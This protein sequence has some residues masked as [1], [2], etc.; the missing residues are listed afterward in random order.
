MKHVLVNAKVKTGLQELNREDMLGL[1]RDHVAKAYMGQ[2]GADATIEKTRNRIHWMAAQVVGDRVLDVGTSEGVLPILLAREGFD[3][4][5]IDI[6]AEAIAFANSLR[7]REPEAIRERVEFRNG[8]LFQ[9]SDDIS[10]DTVVLGEVLEHVANVPKFL[11]NALR[12]LK[13]DGRLV[14][15][16][17]FGVFP[18][19]DHKQTFYLSNIREIL[20]PWGYIEHLSVVDGYI[21]ACLRR[22]GETKPS[23]QVDAGNLLTMTEEAVHAALTA[24]LR[25]VD[26]ER[27]DATHRKKQETERAQAAEHREKQ[28]AERA[29]AAEHREKQQAERAQAAEHREK[30]QAERAQAAEH[31]EKQQAE[32]AQAAEHRE[33]QQAERAQAAEHREK[34]E[35]E[36]KQA[37]EQK[38]SALTEQEERSRALLC[39]V[40]AKLSGVAERVGGLRPALQQFGA[41]LDAQHPAISMSDPRVAPVVDLAKSRAPE[42]AVGVE[43]GGS[44]RLALNFDPATAPQEKNEALIVIRFEAANGRVLDGPYPKTQTSRHVGSY[45]YLYPVEAAS[46]DVALDLRAPEEAR[47]MRISPRIWRPRRELRLRNRLEIRPQPERDVL[48]TLRV[49]DDMLRQ[50]EAM[51]GDGAPQPT[52][53][54]P[55]P[56]QPRA[57]PSPALPVAAAAGGRQRPKALFI[58]D[59]M[60]EA[61]WSEVFDLSPI[62]AK[63]WEDQASKADCD[64]VLLESCWKGN[65]GSWEYAFTSPGLKHAN[66]QRL[67]SVLDR[68]RGRGLPLVF[69]NKEDP[70][71]FDRFLPIA[72]RVSHIFTTDSNCL[73]AYRDAAP[74]VQVETL[75]FAA[76]PGLCNPTGR[77]QTESEN[78]CFAGAYYPEG[79]DERLRQM[80]YVLPAIERFGGAIYDRYSHLDTDRY[81]FP[82]RYRSFLRPSVPFREMAG[83]YKRFKVF[84]N[85]NTIIDSPTMLSRRV[86]E[87]LASGTPV[88]SA[89]SAALEAQFPDIVATGRTEAEI[90]EQVERL[91]SDE[92]Y[93]LRVSQRGMR[94]VFKA[95]TY[96]HRAATMARV[97]GLKADAD[98]TP[99]V[100][101][102][103]ASCR[104]KNVDRIVENVARQTHPNCEVMLVLTPN[105]GD[106]DV[107]RLSALAELTNI[108]RVEI[109]IFG[110]E[111]TLGRC[112]NEA[113]RLSQGNFIAKFDDDNFYFENFLSDLLFPFAFGNYDVVGKESYFCYLGGRDE[114]IWRFP[115]KRFQQTHFVAGDAMILRRRV[116]EKTAFPEKRVGE[117]TQ[118]LK[119][120]VGYG[121]QIFAADHFNF[122]KYRAPNITDHTWRESEDLLMRRSKPVAR[123][124]ATDGVRV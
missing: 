110:P 12:C 72:S 116:F 1:A 34:Q 49:F 112:L 8:S 53:P 50:A 106:A 85:V 59:E 100:S 122:I 36:R 70:M 16:T 43:G 44:Y 6:N 26:S 42:F 79:H 27:R 104:P 87:L 31:R 51:L 124:L 37:T 3:V 107:T 75:P 32:R 78:V 47:L 30:Q 118:L 74:D 19:H 63:G 64:F 18:D 17:P 89:P 105:F 11:E 123:G 119:D 84:L 61:S 73:P 82:E 66:A 96:A 90:T 120:I 14:T 39:E 7:E 98:P 40:T 24:L 23:T 91:L 71:H 48:P 20:E 5:G 108:R 2:W 15:T 9:S 115:E 60:S 95:H 22:T 46:G 114:L 88:V 117:D 69:W 35:A 94:S 113:V 109:R 57:A 83:L 55:E 111:V 81:R 10:F 86:Y 97:L 65:G 80:N 103:I 45:R 101:I 99:L 52:R 92:E 67:L 13:N 33:K 21:R 93:W 62:D 76:A 4:V 41:A 121:G 29:Q 58:L 56:A 25:Q 102:V 68:V 28:Q 38:I 54:A 77:L